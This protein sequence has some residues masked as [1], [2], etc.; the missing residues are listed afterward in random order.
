MSK[1]SIQQ[2]IFD[3]ERNQLEVDIKTSASNL[4]DLIHVIKSNYLKRINFKNKK[5]NKNNI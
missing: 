3:K 2:K 1:C 4:S 5:Y